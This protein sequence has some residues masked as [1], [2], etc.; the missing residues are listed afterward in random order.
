M[1]DGNPVAAKPRAVPACVKNRLREIFLVIA[2]RF[3]D[4]RLTKA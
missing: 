2:G 1:M 4:V 3:M